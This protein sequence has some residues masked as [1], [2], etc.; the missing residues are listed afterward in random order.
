MTPP[1]CRTLRL[2]AVLWI[3]LWTTKRLRTA[4]TTPTL[5]VSA[6]S[7]PRTSDRSAARLALVPRNP[8]AFTGEVPR[9]PRYGCE[10]EGPPK[11]AQASLKGP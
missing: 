4:M 11:Q 9:S 3:H 7:N 6:T 8:R 10:R 5:S 1:T 2:T